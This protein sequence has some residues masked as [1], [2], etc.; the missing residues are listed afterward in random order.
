[1]GAKKKTSVGLSVFNSSIY[2]NE[3]YKVGGVR[4]RRGLGSMELWPSVGHWPK[5]R[6]QDS[7]GANYM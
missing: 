1:V 3:K 7:K 5:V 4:Q 6:P 2:P